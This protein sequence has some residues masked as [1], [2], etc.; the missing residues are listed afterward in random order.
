MLNKV[1]ITTEE[2]VERQSF[3]GHFYFSDTEYFF[4]KDFCDD[5]ERHEVYEKGKERLICKYSKEEIKRITGFEFY[6]LKNTNIT[7]Y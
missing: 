6:I 1:Y 5:E 4:I 2:A 7:A 3:F